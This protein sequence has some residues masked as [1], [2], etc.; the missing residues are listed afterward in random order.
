MCP[1]CQ[2]GL[3]ESGFTKLYQLQSF[4]ICCMAQIFEEENVD[5]LALRKLDTYNNDE[6]VAGATLTIAS[7]NIW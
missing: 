3:L 6:T 2:N 7:G 4:L 1:F 5:K